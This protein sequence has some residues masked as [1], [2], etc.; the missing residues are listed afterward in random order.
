MALNYGLDAC[1]DEREISLIACFFLLLDFQKYFASVLQQLLFFQ[2]FLT[3]E[4]ESRIYE[5]YRYT[6]ATTNVHPLLSSLVVYTCPVKFSGF[7][8]SEG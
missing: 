1:S 6:G 3:A 7:A 2:P 8:A 4:E 5:Q